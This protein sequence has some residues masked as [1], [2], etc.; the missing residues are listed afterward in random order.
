MLA[1]AVVLDAQ[2]SKNRE[3]TRKM[4]AFIQDD[5]QFLNWMTAVEAWKSMTNISI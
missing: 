1:A 2:N 4:L 3:L 5:K